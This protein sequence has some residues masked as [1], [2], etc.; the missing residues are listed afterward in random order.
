MTRTHHRT[1][2]DPADT[3]P[4]DTGSFDTGAPGPV[5]DV[6]ELFARRG[7]GHYGE[8]VDQRR[9]ALQAA[10]LALSEGADVRLVA[11]ALLHD[12]GHLVSGPD[13]GAPFDDS[14]DDHHESI[15]ARWLAPRFGPDVAR[16]VALHVM[17]K[18]YRCTVDP[19]YLADLSPTSLRTLTAQG[20]LLDERALA[21][22]AGRPGSDD[23]LAVR[24]WDERAKDPTAATP[25]LPAFLPVLQR[26]STSV[27]TPL[28]RGAPCDRPGR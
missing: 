25:D 16:A 8:T 24:D 15:G 14:V 4:V 5:A 18:R 11:A 27:T 17:A 2:Q 3:G 10:T 20:G 21:R 1:A 28:P 23:A 26:L 19:A 12:I 7:D 6:L 22:F 13:P 9:H